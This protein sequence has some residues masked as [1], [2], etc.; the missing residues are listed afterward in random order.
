LVVLEIP[1]PYLYAHRNM[2]KEFPKQPSWKM[3]ADILYAAK[4]YE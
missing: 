4:I 3:I 1:Y 2:D